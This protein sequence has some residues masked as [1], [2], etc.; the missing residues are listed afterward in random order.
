MADIQR[1]AY[2][3]AGTDTD[4][5]KTLVSCAL[6][7]AAAAAGYS[8]LGM[9]P[10]AAGASSTQ[11]GLRNDDAIQ[12]HAA[13]TL[14]LAYEQ[15]NPV[16]LPEAASPH[17]AAALAGRKVSVER[18]SGFCRGVLAQRA[19]LTLIEGAGGWRVPLNDREYLSDLAKALKLPVLLVVGMRLGCLNHALLTAEAL[20]RDGLTLAGWI[21]NRIDPGLHHYEQNRDT[22]LQRFEAP[23]VAEIPH[24]AAPLRTADARHCF[25]VDQLFGKPA[26]RL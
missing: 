4:V 19:D 17:I 22:L 16:C 14:K 10:V 26:A 1:L 12:L 13:S 25:A 9:K 24:L 23:L 5:G 15:I 11:Q 6:L 2:F 18:L 21:A 20:A 3:V 8:T 7:G